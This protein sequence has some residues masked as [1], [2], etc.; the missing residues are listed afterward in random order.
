MKKEENV[1]PGQTL[2]MP[3]KLNR[4]FLMAKKFGRDLNLMESK[5]LWITKENSYDFDCKKIRL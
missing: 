2:W 5:S 4:L 1:D 3:K